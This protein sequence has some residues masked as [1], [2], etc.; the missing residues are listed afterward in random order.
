[1]TDVKRAALAGLVTV[2]CASTGCTSTP[3][4]AASTQDPAT[5]NQ[6][7]QQQPDPRVQAAAE[8]AQLPPIAPHGVDHSGRKQ[9]GR[10]SYYAPEFTNRKMANGNRFDPNSAVAASKSLP[11]GTTARVTNLRNGMTATV[12]VEDRGPFIDGRIV[13]LAPKV[14][15]QL[16][17]KKVGV[18]PV[19]VAPIV[20]PQPDGG[21]KLGAGAAVAGV[22]EVAEAPAILANGR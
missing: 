5:A 19:V 9:Q 6:A 3:G 11:L 21:M 4:P 13:D 18:V 1:M 10:A 14:A 2:I 7:A 16:G 20:V 8:L 15:E 22:D 12:K 17:M